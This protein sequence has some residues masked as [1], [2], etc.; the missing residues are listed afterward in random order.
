MSEPRT[1]TFL[2]SGVLITAARSKDADQQTALS[3]VD[4]AKRVFLTTPFVALEVIPKATFNRQE[5]ERS[6]Y[7]RYLESATK[8]S[9]TESYGQPCRGGGSAVRDGSS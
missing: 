2:D 6:F 9:G 3:I 7:V 1:R 8:L 5:P 4:D